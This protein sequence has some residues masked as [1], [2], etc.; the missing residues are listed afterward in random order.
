MDWTEVFFCLFGFFSFSLQFINPGKPRADCNGENITMIYTD[1]VNTGF[2]FVFGFF[3]IYLY[4]LL[5]LSY[6]AMKWS[7]WDDL[8]MYTKQWVG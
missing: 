3:F 5:T 4:I 1:S 8:G 6:Y 2:F 7:L